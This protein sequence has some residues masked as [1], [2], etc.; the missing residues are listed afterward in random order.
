MGLGVY[1]VLIACDGIF[2]SKITTLGP[3][4]GFASLAAKAGTVVVSLSRAS[5]FC[6]G[7]ND[8]DDKEATS[9]VQDE[10]RTD[11]SFMNTPAYDEYE[12]FLKD[13]RLR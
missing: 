10:N 11:L 1:S 7:F 4:S 9:R 5:R 12:L 3:N 13:K 8:K 2:G 6:C